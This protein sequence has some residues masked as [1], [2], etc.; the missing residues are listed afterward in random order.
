MKFGLLP[1]IHTISDS[2][3]DLSMVGGWVG[4]LL[5]DCL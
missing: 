1:E 4:G 3:L 2:G 5:F